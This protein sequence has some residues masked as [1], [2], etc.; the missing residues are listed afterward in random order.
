MEDIVNVPPAVRQFQLE[1]DS[2][3][4]VNNFKWSKVFGSQFLQG[5]INVDVLSIWPYLVS[6]LE[7]W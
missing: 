3:D 4:G 1:I 7:R 5:I 2:S 6:F